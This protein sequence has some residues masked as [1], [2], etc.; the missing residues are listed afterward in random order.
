MTN[1]YDTLFKRGLTT[2]QR[3]FSTYYAGR[4]PS[5]LATTGTLSEAAMIAVFRR[6]VDEGH[7]LLAFHVARHVL[8]G[9]DRNDRMTS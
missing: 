9:Q 4:S 2:S 5:Y 7:W 1:I 3:D 8:F 6:L